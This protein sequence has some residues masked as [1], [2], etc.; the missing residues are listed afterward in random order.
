MA[1][2]TK[3]SQAVTHPSTNLARCCLTSVIWRELVCSTWYGRRHWWWGKITY[4]NRKSY[5]LICRNIEKDLAYSTKYSQAVTHPSTN[6]ARC[7]LTSVIWRELVCSTWYGRRHLL[8]RKKTFK[9]KI[10]QNQVH[11][12]CKMHTDVYILLSSFELSRFDDVIAWKS[13]YT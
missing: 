9:Q 8:G 7:C 13:T 3:Y 5:K 12:I 1:Y 4:S 11:R 2:S 10:L 6:L